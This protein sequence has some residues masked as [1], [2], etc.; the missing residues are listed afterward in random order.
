MILFPVL[1]LAAGLLIGR[2]S[3]FAVTLLA[4]I[5]GFSLLAALT[6]EFD[7][8]YDPFVWIDVLVA[9]LATGLGILLRFLWQ[10]RAAP[11]PPLAQP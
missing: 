11:E 1:G 10:T 6:D 4:A 2:R 7:G 8:W 5:A 9:L 3:A